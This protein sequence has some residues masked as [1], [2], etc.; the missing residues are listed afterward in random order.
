M[1]LET[2]RLITPGCTR[3]KA[4]SKSTCRIRRIRESPMT[5][6]PGT[7]SAPPESPVPDPRATM[8]SPASRATLTHAPPR[9]LAPPRQFLGVPRQHHQP[10][11]DAKAGEP[12]GLVGAELFRLADGVA[13]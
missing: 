5:T 3:M 4:L 13:F 8:A 12:V 9:Q 11:R 1:C 7:G 10:G 2:S 6:Q